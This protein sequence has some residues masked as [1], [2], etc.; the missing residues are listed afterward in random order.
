M[1][2]VPMRQISRVLPVVVA[3]L[4]TST[5]S[6]GTKQRIVLRQ[7]PVT[8]LVQ[9]DA[10][11]GGGVTPTVP[12]QPGETVARPT[13]PPPRPGLE[14]AAGRNGGATDVG[15]TATGIDLGATVVKSGVGATFLEEVP[16]AMEAVVGEVNRAGGV[17]GRLLHLDTVDDSWDAARGQQY[18]RTFI[19]EGKFALAVSPSSE[20]LDAA[21]RNGDIERAGI[22]VVGADGMLI[23][24]YTDPWVWPIAASTITTMHV[25]A[26]EAAKQG[27]KTFG[28]VY[29]TDYHFGVEGAAAFRGALKRL[30]PGRDVL[31]ADVGI[32]SLQSSYKNTV[33]GFNRACDQCDFVGMLLEP[34]TA[35]QW[36][37]DGGGFG[38]HGT[39]GG[40]QPLFVDGF[41]RACGQACNGMQVWTGFR[42]PIAPFDDSPAVVRYVRTVRARS[43]TIDVSNPFVEGGYLGMRLLVEA[44]RQVGPDLTRARLKAVLD[45][46]EFDEGLTKPLR[47]SA[48]RF[49]NDSVQAFSIVVNAGSFAGWRYEQT[50]FVADRWPGMDV[51]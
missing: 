30:F 18:I 23:S 35:L 50:G 47:W 10:P 40:P 4:G 45:R 11:R 39:G 19:D 41:A 46:I 51:S 29:E 3:L 7:R 38:E 24:Q 34:A 42:P 36:I 12:A 8:T 22:P 32:E 33:D 16:I 6:V 5:L 26:S 15:V 2:P 44:L 31:L 25:M 20:G 9:P 17:C 13:V 28:L 43:S 49:A 1:R 37:R 14:C 27:A 48:D 21:I